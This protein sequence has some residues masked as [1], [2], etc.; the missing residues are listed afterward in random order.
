MVRYE[1]YDLLSKRHELILALA[2]LPMNSDHVCCTGVRFDN[3]PCWLI[4][5]SVQS[6]WIPPN[7]ST[8]NVWKT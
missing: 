4:E 6:D 8:H 1:C 7:L 2:H 5:Y 3:R